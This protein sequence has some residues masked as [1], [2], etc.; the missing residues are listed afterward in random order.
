M[1]GGVL[2]V[3][4]RSVCSCHSGITPKI[5]RINER[6]SKSVMG[7]Y[8]T[9]VRALHRSCNFNWRPI[10]SGTQQS[11]FGCERDFTA[12]QYDFAC[13]S[14]A[15]GLQGMCALL[16]I[17]FAFLSASLRRILPLKWTEY[18]TKTPF[19]IHLTRALAKFIWHL[20]TKKSAPI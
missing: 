14:V 13:K 4:N 5:S 17:I 1:L 8:F 19:K 11:A 6:R 15:S 3:I 9:V 18:A 2:F 12:H 20:T 7:A 16:R 10:E